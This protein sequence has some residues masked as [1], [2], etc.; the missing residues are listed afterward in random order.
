MARLAAFALLIVRIVNPATP[1][2]QERAAH[3]LVP[4]ESVDRALATG[5]RHV[6]R[7]DLAAGEFA[8]VTVDQ[9]GIDAT[10]EVLG[11]DGQTVAA[12]QDNWKTSG[13]ERAIVVAEA[14]GPVLLAVVPGQPRGAPGAYS[15]RV[16]DRRVATAADR[17]LRDATVLRYDVTRL[18]EVD[19][20]VEALPLAMRAVTLAERGAPAGDLSV[21]LA[22][23]ALAEAYAEKRSYK[24]A[25]A[26][27]QRALPI[28][29][30]VLG[31]AD[32][33]TAFV[34]G[35]LATAYRRLGQSLVAERTARAALK[36]LEAALGPDHLA[37]A[38]CLINLGTIRQ[39]AGDFD[40]AE[41]LARRA[42]AITEKSGGSD[43]I[44]APILNNLGIL[45]LDRQRPD[46]AHDFLRRS[47]ELGESLY[48]P[49]SYWMANTLVNLGIV[50][51]QRKAYDQAEAYYVK[52]LAIREKLVP[53]DHPDIASNLNNLATLYSSRGDAVRSLE[54]HRRALA[55][56][57]KA[58]GPYGAGTLMSLGNI[59]RVYA[60]S[61]DVA[62]AVAFQLRSD[63]AL[64]VQLALNLA[65][66]SERQRLASA[67]SIAERTDRTISLS[68]GVAARD[69]GASRLAALVLLQRKGRVLDAMTDTIASFRQRAGAADGS[70]IE[71]LGET[72]RN[73]A[74]LALNGRQGMT[75]EEHRG[76]I[77]ALEQKKERV[78]SAI[79]EHDAEFRARAIPVT[80]EAIQAAIPRDA[81][82]VEYA[83]FRPFNPKAATNAEAYGP[84]HY[85]AY[86]IA[87]EGTPRG[88]DLGAAAAIDEAIARLRAALRDPTRRDV[89]ALA[90]AVDA[91]VLSPVRPAAGTASR[92]LISPDGALNLI[93]FE[94]LVADDG[95]F[96]IH[97]YAISYLT[98]GR[99][100]LRM[101]VAR[102]SRGAA[103][104][105]A[106]PAF[107]APP[108]SAAAPARAGSSRQPG[109]ATDNV[110]SSLYFAP[111]SGTAQ[112][113]REIRA[114]FPE[115]TILSRE[116][117][118]KARL[119]RVP[120]PEILH[121]A[122][123]GFFLQDARI[124]NPLL[125]S[126]LALAGANTGAVP[127][128]S[129]ILTA[130]EAANLDL[131]GTKLVTLS[132]C[133]T[134]L[135]TVRNGEGVYGMRRAFVLAGAE[136]LVMSLW[137]VSDYVTRQMMS[138]YYRGLKKGRGRGASLRDAQLALLA[139][140]NRRHPFYWASFIQAGDWTP[141]KGS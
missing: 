63:A 72:T 30:R 44:R 8:A 110:A 128:G 28:F 41:A 66:G 69:P 21:A 93:P 49:D 52:A 137:P 126:G 111:L 40:E 42:L 12:F 59:A 129:G 89:M 1:L 132:A 108:A 23:R 104:I 95:R 131:W 32:P 77:A 57:E 127:T 125:R 80:L 100:L 70:L 134:G 33:L 46:D 61:G 87:R 13:I 122:S 99:D 136:T 54:T 107:G 121:I 55:I 6:Y 140:A 39:D 84:P 103:V 120:A 105:V 19:K 114:L 130:L 117:A 73:L 79:S 98:S 51:R 65:I 2:T 139:R 115:A 81:A 37:V 76:A 20:A 14:S 31:P 7:L 67:A 141:L 102:P 88:F 116:D 26:A 35:R 86:V 64:E 135:G 133:D 47:A 112:E 113:A 138:S 91:R 22:T 83:V 56:W 101:A 16:S 27:Y 94:A 24:E 75:A 45:A 4:G 58:G 123:H 90:R 10:V 17:D 78:E 106:D 50:A 119:A 62:N 18:L 71:Q 124:D 5:D 92:L 25:E 109:D 68:L 34:S 36:T 29:E 48:G 11:S 60:A 74:R 53:P 15:I 85:A 43:R 97:R 118:S 38:I 3:P 9:R 96:A 82:L